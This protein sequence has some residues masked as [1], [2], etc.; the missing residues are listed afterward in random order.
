VSS[1]WWRACAVPAVTGLLIAG[2]GS[3][4]AGR[5][6]RAAPA[7]PPQ[8]AASVTT[9]TGTSWAI[10][11]MGGASSQHDDFWQLFTRPAGSAKWRQVTPAGVA[12][13]GGL[14]AGVT[15]PASLV[16]GFRPSQDLSFSPLAATADGGATW[17]AGNLVSPGLAG[18]PDALAADAS[19][20][21]IALSQG[22]S[23]QLGPR[24]GAAWTRLASAQSLARTA[25]G[26]ACGLTGL[27]AVAFGTRGGSGNRGG[28][29]VPLLAGA[30][31]HQGIAGIFA[32]RG[33]RWQPA[34]P[35][36]PA[37]L[38]GRDVTVLRMAT[39]GTRT[40]ALLQ[41]GT[42]PA[43]TVL[44]AWSGDGGGHW[45]LSAPLRIAGAAVRSASFGAAGGVGLVLGHG[46]NQGAGQGQ[47]EA[48]A[49]PGASWQA[50]PALPRW[51]AT[52]AVGPAGR[53]DALTAHAS[54][55]ADWQLHAAPAGW[56]PVQTLHITIPYGSSG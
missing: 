6:P 20:Q 45:R 40:Q 5:P 27:T 46:G 48:L 37:P 54:S 50:L 10:V 33:G 18:V 15:G 42:G 51:T 29:G 49:G 23:V 39:L 13:N 38:A 11:V 22:G 8:L 12:D 30:C 2:C 9:A 25:A 16:T 19:A 53:V 26:R 1:R 28:S 32:L 36:V 4:A 7:A 24:L 21:L 55:F 31:G 35:P 34:G 3:V 43:A 14:V 52:L 56:S 47:G 41:S 44:A 17:S